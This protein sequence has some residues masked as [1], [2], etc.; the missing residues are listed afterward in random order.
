MFSGFT[1]ST[2]S[3]F[4]AIEI[5]KKRVTCRVVHCKNTR[6]STRSASRV[7]KQRQGCRGPGGQIR[8]LEIDRRDKVVMTASMIR[9]RG[10]SSTKQNRKPRQFSQSP[11]HRAL[12]PQ[13]RV[14]M[15]GNSVRPRECARWKSLSTGR[16]MRLEMG[17]SEIASYRL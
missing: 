16:G 15:L 7:P 1:T 9:R 12:R 3:A 8:S 10:R 4:T 2:V 13:S 5:N 14:A 6:N 11:Q 17:A